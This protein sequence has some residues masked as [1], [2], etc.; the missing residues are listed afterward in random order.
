[1]SKAPGREKPILATISSRHS[2]YWITCLQAGYER[3]SVIVALPL[4]YSSLMRNVRYVSIPW[5]CGIDG[6]TDESIGFSSATSARWWI[7]KQSP[8]V[9][10]LSD[11]FLW[12]VRIVQ[13]PHDLS[14]RWATGEIIGNPCMRLLGH[15]VYFSP[16]IDSIWRHW[17]ET[18]PLPHSHYITLLLRIIP[19]HSPMKAW[20]P[21][22][23]LVSLVKSHVSNCHVMIHVNDVFL[24]AIHKS[25]WLWGG[26]RWNTLKYFNEKD[27]DPLR[28][29]WLLWRKRYLWRKAPSS[30]L[31]EDSAHGCN[32]SSRIDLSIVSRRCCPLDEDAS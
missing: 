25:R 32:F 10:E 21:E 19:S 29:H 15:P 7:E 4:L 30:D 31:N 20:K 2:R 16:L 22:S 13:G 11:Y 23:L 28:I 5:E 9:R 1:M 17:G 14:L 18:F 26:K 12:I 27:K 6:L 8:L 3:T 24:T